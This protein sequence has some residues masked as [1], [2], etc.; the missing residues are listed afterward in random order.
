MEK[1]SQLVTHERS[2][3]GGSYFDSFTHANLFRSY[4]PYEFGVKGAQLF[5]AK[6]GEDMINKKFTYYT[7]AQKQVHMLPGG[8]DEYSWYLMGSTAGQYRFT[9]FLGTAGAQ[10]GKGNLRFKIAIDRT[11]G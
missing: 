6:I 11:V 1:R 10:I 8:V 5:S 4:K 7:V 2:N 9:E 3:W